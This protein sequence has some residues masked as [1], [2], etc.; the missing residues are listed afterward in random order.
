METE[1]EEGRKP[2]STTLKPYTDYLE[3]EG[4]QWKLV[5]PRQVETAPWTL[6]KCQY[7]CP[8]YGKSRCCPPHSPDYRRT[9]EILDSYRRGILFSVAGDSNQLA[10]ETARRLFLGGFYKSLALGGHP[11]TLCESCDLETCRFPRRRS[12]PWKPAGS[13]CLPPPAGA[14]LR[15]TPLP[16]RPRGHTANLPWYW[17]NKEGTD[18]CS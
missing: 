1:K 7:G 5:D 14:G 8:R 13:T 6:F 18:C 10:V 12:L 2:M 4:A 11:C 15:C 16:R 3:E 17:W 9:R